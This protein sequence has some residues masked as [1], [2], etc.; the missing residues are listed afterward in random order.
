M[1]ALILKRTSQFANYFRDYSIQ[2]NNKTAT[3]LSNGEKIEIDLEANTYR[4]QAKIDWMSSEN[5]SISLK[6]NEVKTIEIGC[7]SI[8]ASA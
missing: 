3:T 4:I 8:T 2:I 1:A 5:L 6:E 7:P